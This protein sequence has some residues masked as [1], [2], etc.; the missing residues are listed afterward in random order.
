M[1]ADVDYAL[2]AVLDAPGLVGRDPV[3]VAGAL[4]D[5][6][7]TVVQYRAK[8]PGDRLDSSRL[9]A[10]RDLLRSRG[11]P[12]L[13]NDDLD[14]A[15]RLESGVH[16]G[17]GDLPVREARKRGGEGMLVGATV[18]D[19]READV[20]V[21]AGASYLSVGSIFFT[22]TKPDIQVVGLDRLGE[23][24]ARSPRPT[25]AIG[26]IDETRIEAVLDRGA[27]GIALVS[28]LLGA[29]DP[30][31]AARRIRDRI[32]R[33][34]ASADPMGGGSTLRPGGAL[35]GRRGRTGGGLTST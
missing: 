31:T 30:C 12:F 11:I 6:G 7:A 5:G 25:I 33:V 24:C 3:R 9:V 23:I 19:V 16:L 8:E 15:L 26:G 10:L 17:Q 21:A 34:R 14:L 32:D 18:H 4:C 27:A 22:A 13:I 2:Y 1:A 28:A 29:D 35:S 20:A